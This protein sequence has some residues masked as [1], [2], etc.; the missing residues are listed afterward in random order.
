MFIL[1][2]SNCNHTV[3]QVSLQGIGVN[4]L[5]FNYQILF[6]IFAIVPDFCTFC[7][8][9]FISLFI[10]SFLFYYVYV[11]SLS[12]VYPLVPVMWLWLVCLKTC[13]RLVKHE[14]S[15]IVWPLVFLRIKKIKFI[16]T[17]RFLLYCGSGSSRWTNFHCKNWR[18]SDHEPC[19][20]LWNG[21]CKSGRLESM[22]CQL[23]YTHNDN[24][25]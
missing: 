6:V 9:G 21:S 15:D 20:H 1:L 2:S 4:S 5:H 18:W 13:L 10:Y 19:P 7:F 8:P 22:P 12:F 23:A 17:Y 25:C 14:G 3:T 11:L 24:F 16:R